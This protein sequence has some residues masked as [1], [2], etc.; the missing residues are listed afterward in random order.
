MSRLTG[1]AVSKSREFHPAAADSNTQML[2]GGS[3]SGNCSLSESTLSNPNKETNKKSSVFGGEGANSFQCE[4]LELVELQYKGKV[5][6]IIC[7]ALM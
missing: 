2:P 5:S 1:L 4:E 6:E 3:W 7:Y